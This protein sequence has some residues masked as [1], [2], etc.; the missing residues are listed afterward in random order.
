MRYQLICAALI[1][2]FATSAMAQEWEING[3]KATT[4]SPAA[5][6]DTNGFWRNIP[7]IGDDSLSE[8]TA[9]VNYVTGGIGDDER[10]AIEAARKNYNVHVTSASVSG[11]FVEDAKVVI[12]D[13]DGTS[14][15]DVKAGPLLY[16]QL[17]AGTYTLKATH[18]EQVK[19][20]KIVITKKKPNATVHL[21]WK[22]P[23]VVTTK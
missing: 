19:T 14:L 8:N 23:A 5:E 13:K 6:P 10:A 21:G 22:I 17:P 16:V 15:L 3:A 9:S 18:G 20:Q 2:A 11:A 12:T 1:T 4:E 7:L